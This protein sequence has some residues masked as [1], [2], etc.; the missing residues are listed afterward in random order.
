MAQWLRAQRSSQHPPNS[1]QLSVIPIYLLKMP[2]SSCGV[3]QPSGWN[4]DMYLVHTFN[5][6]Q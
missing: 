4:K 2:V 5:P 1:L 6:K 3:A